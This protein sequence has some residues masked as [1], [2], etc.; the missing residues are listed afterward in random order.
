MT[1]ITPSLLYTIAKN[2]VI[3]VDLLDDG[4][5]GWF[6][7]AGGGWSVGG[8]GPGGGSRGWCG[9]GVVKAAFVH[10]VAALGGRPAEK[11]QC[12]HLLEKRQT[13]RTRV[14]SHSYC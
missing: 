6:W 3:P 2:N 9:L 8:G 5:W 4:D 12:C 13:V 14:I 10:V 1:G 11:A 7:L